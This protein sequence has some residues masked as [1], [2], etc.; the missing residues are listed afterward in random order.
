MGEGET[1]IVIPEQRSLETDSLGNGQVLSP[2]L[3]LRCLVLQNGLKV[4]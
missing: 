4:L 2:A 3:R 1:G